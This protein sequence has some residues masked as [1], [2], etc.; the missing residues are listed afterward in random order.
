MARPWFPFYFADYESKT[1]HLSLAEHGAYLLLIGA[2]Y[3]TGKPLPANAVQLQKICRAFAPDE[4]QA[5]HS[6][7]AQ[8]FRLE[9][10]TYYHARCDE[11]IQKSNKISEVR[12]KVAHDRHANAPA[13]AHANASAIAPTITTTS[14][15]TSTNHKEDTLCPASRTPP[16]SVNHK[17]ETKALA[18]KVIQFLNEK[19]GRNYNATGANLELLSARI[20]DGA[21]ERDLFQVIAKKTRDWRGDPKME[22]FLRPKTLF[23]RT[24]FEN[25]LGEL[26]QRRPED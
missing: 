22:P 18:I 6:V 7:L 3:K 16:P 21:T 2:Y 12:S 8:Y 24:N 25:Y 13:I 19:T 23:N 20:R 5:L 26:G 14:T 1:A 15:I 10:E 17:A 9:G 11:E 4:V